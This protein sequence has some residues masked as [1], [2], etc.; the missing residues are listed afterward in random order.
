MKRPAPAPSLDQKATTIVPLLS[1]KAVKSYLS[2]KQML[3][4][5]K[6]KRQKPK[7]KKK[8]K[9]ETPL[10]KAQI[11]EILPPQKPQRPKDAKFLSAFDSQVDKQQVSSHRR[12]PSQRMIKSKRRVLSPGIDE[13]G[14]RSG[15]KKPPKGRSKVSGKTRK[16]ARKTAKPKSAQTTQ[17]SQRAQQD[18]K[19]TAKQTLPKGE[20]RFS[21]SGRSGERK[22]AESD[23]A[24]QKA[25]N[26]G[27]PENWRTLLPTLGPKDMKASNGSID[28]VKNVPRGD[29][30][31][32]NTRAYKHAWFFNRIK[33]SVRREWRAAEQYRRH[34]P[35][36]RVY[37]IR[38]RYTIVDVTLN[39]NGHL[40]GVS[41]RKDSG[42]AVLDEAALSAFR[43]A[44][45]FPNP[46]AGL[47]D[48]DGRIRFQFGFFLE[49]GG[50]SFKL[51][52]P[53]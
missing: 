45:P 3:A 4:G 48:Q 36:G 29:K 28:H 32:L 30:T 6:N 37:G 31:F 35:N 2:P 12:A 5:Q 7:Q 53:Y 46:P 26:Q 10:K 21:P 27:A 18:R 8:K 11:V 17:R 25:G 38:D 23:Q 40:E 43:T 44:Q 14:S 42:V 20:G 50:S 52:R 22:T 34:D 49:I 33:R 16:A 39:P 51:F 9:L 24:A 19:S 1:Q 15:Q 47:R 13:L 41:I